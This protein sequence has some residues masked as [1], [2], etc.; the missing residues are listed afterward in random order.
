MVSSSLLRALDGPGEGQAARTACARVVLKT[1]L[2][3]DGGAGL[4]GRAVLNPVIGALAR[5]GGAVAHDAVDALPRRWIFAPSAAM[6]S[7]ARGDG[8]RRESARSPLD[9]SW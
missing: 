7:V 4:R 5:E 1:R 3:C 6:E 8:G 9:G 2:G